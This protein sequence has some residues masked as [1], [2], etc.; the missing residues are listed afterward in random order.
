MAI[1]DIP[2]YEGELAG[3]PKSIWDQ[4][5]F[6]GERKIVC[7]WADRVWM[8]AELDSAEEAR[9]PYDDGPS[10]TVTDPVAVVPYRAKID[11]L[12]GGAHTN[13]T[14]AMAAY[15]KAVI[16]VTY[17]MWYQSYGGSNNFINER[18]EPWTE[19]KTISG[20]GLFWRSSNGTP[21]KDTETIGRVYSGFNY[22]TTFRNQYVLPVELLSYCGH[23]NNADVFAPMLG[24]NFEAETLLFRGV[25]L[26]RAAQNSAQVWHVHRVLS[27]RHYGWNKEWN[28]A[29]GEAGTGDYEEVYTATGR[30]RNFPMRQF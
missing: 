25:T 13:A 7:A 2:S 30:Y 12:P 23:V 5:D 26:E 14:G 17:G 28:P 19:N 9:W 18:I 1:T 29:G 10:Q 6:R 22:I 21:F 20:T 15:D 8:L 11:P 24:I 4:G 27:Y 3:W 16:T